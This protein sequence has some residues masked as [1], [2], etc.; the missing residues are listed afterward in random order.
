M[1]ACVARMKV[2]AVRLRL[3]VNGMNSTYI[4][5]EFLIDQL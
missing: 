5:R 4:F 2:N 1:R 3:V